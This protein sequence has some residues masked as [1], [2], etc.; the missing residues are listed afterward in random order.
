MVS[1]CD[2]IETTIVNT[3]A[4]S[5]IFLG[6]KEEPCS[7][8]R[9]G[10]RIRLAARELLKYCSMASLSGLGRLYKQLEGSRKVDKGGETGL[11]PYKRPPPDCDFL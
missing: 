2:V 7:K 9:E 8:R 10:C 11:D 6:H 4:K 3:G 1:H 5:L